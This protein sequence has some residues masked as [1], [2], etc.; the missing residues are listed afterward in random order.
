MVI[1]K[2]LFPLAFSVS[3]SH[4]M[5]KLA[6]ALQHSSLATTP[7]RKVLEWLLSYKCS[8]WLELLEQGIKLGVEPRLGLAEN[9]YTDEEGLCPEFKVDKALTC[10]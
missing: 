10:H 7:L 5:V 9:H 4:M 2:L 8:R 1:H 6:A 3:S